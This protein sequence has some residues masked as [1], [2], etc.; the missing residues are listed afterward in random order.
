M[1]SPKKVVYLVRHGQSKANTRPV[2]QPPDSPLTE[3][4]LAQARRLGER[5]AKLKFD[6]LIASPLTRAR[7]TAETIGEMTGHTPEFSELFVERRKPEAIMGKSHANLPAL[8]M[9][10]RWEDSLYRP[11]LRV[12]DGENFD[13]LA[14]RT[15]RALEHLYTRPEKRILVVTHALFLRD[16]VARVVMGDALT[17]EVLKRFRYKT[18]MEN[19]SLTALV[20]GRH[21][22]GMEW[23]LW[24]FNDHSHLG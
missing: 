17:G 14:G 24:T 18:M 9:W 21:L 19:T 3:T 15:D 7:Q 6:A 4:G 13:D 8:R 5:A 1:F 22:D 16:L 20:Y 11:G 2:F 12:E 10:K 23:R